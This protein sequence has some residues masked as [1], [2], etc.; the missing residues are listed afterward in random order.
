MNRPS[1]Q[2]L[3]LDKEMPALDGMDLLQQ[4]PVDICCVMV[5]GYTEFAST[6]YNTYIIDYLVNPITFSR[7]A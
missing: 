2:L 5:T 1:V 4:L 6:A 7:L 3:I